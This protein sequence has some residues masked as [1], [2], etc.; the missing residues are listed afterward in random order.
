MTGRSS[1]ERGLCLHKHGV[2]IV[3]IP[4]VPDNESRHVATEMDAMYF[5]RT[6]SQ[7]RVSK[8]LV[9]ANGKVPAEV[10][11]CT[12]RD[13]SRNKLIPISSTAQIRCPARERST[14]SLRTSFCVVLF[15]Y[16]VSLW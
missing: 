15:L 7:M 10:S 1:T 9:F 2:F 12:F 3:L 6:A 16:M 11:V 4:S 14:L 8:T 5:R 13:A